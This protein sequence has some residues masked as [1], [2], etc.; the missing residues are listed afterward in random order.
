MGDGWW[1]VY[2]KDRV[3]AVRAEQVYELPEDAQ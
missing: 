3:F 1:V 2:T